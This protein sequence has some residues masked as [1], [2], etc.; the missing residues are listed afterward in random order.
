MRPMSSGGLGA[1]VGPTGRHRRDTM[2]AIALTSTTL[3]AAFLV[4]GLASPVAAQ[5]PDPYEEMPALS[6][7]ECIGGY[8]W[9][10]PNLSECFEH[11][12]DWVEWTVRLAEDGGNLAICAIIRALGGTC[13]T[14]EN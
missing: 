1:S 11:A 4:V 13:P 14:A 3:V 5:D 8:P 12:I 2:K 7:D 10:D 9:P 6:P